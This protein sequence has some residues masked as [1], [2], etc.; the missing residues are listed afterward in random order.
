MKFVEFMVFIC[1][2]CHQ[3]YEGTKYAEEQ[4]HL[5]ISKLMPALLSP[6]NLEPAYVF[7]EKFKIDADKDKK[8]MRRKMSKL[9]FQIQKSKMSGL[10]VNEEL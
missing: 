2:I 8:K 5:K 1:R 9:H 4:L 7:D 3:H 6:L 10:E